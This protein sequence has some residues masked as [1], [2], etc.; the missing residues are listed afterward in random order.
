MKDNRNDR[1]VAG[2]CG[3]QGKKT[4]GENTIA[5]KAHPKVGVL[6]NL[7]KPRALEEAGRLQSFLESRG[8][9]PLLE[10][11]QA[12][13]ES[14]FLLA[15]GGDGTL[16]NIAREAASFGVPV[17]GVNLGN[18]GFLTDAEPA[19]AETAIEQV[20]AGHY[21]LE[22]RMMLLARLANRSETFTALNDVCITRGVFS[23]TVRLSVTIN[24]ENMDSYFGDGV[25]ISTPTGS[26]AYNL[27]AGGPILKPDARMMA[28]TPICPHSLYARSTVVGA[29]DVVEITP[30][31]PCLLSADGGDGVELSARE[32]IRVERASW[33][34]V[35]IKTQKRGF[36]QI[37]RNK[38]IQ[39]GGGRD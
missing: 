32:T 11:E 30:E 31:S 25:L 24:G 27:S 21:R 8:C 4:A 26:T 14:D 1:P 10:R 15:L 12:M 18:L 23:K 19:E 13:Q 6:A 29:E 34:A 17:L 5:K 3:E 33:D 39:N 9:V 22:H 38:L 37:L 7:T 2:A 16:L 35:I 36:Y 20:L 28:I